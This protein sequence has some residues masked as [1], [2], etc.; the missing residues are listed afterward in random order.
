MLLSGQFGAG[1]STLARALIRAACGDPALDVPSP[2]YT[3]TQSFSA[4]TLVLHHFDLWRL[5]GPAGL[6]DLGWDEARQ[7]VVIVEWPDRL[8]HLRP[9]DAL[10]LELTLAG[11]ETRQLTVRGWPDRMAG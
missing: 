7:H 8:G 2:S 1:K 4:K 11:P 5:D 10:G 9:D 3:L 6:P